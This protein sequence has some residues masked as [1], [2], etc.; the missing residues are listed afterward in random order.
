MTD[1]QSKAINLSVA[2]KGLILG[3]SSTT[4]RPVSAS[5]SFQAAFSNVVIYF[6]EDFPKQHVGSLYWDSPRQT[7]IFARLFLILSMESLGFLSSPS[8]LSER[9]DW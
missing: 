5:L 1:N 7:G 9:F 8:S 2:E 3:E 4:K 6:S